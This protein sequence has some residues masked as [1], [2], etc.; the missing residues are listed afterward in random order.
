MMPEES[1]HDNLKYHIK[2][3]KTEI[4]KL[5]MLILKAHVV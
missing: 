4:N 2:T 1:R 3:S 5:G